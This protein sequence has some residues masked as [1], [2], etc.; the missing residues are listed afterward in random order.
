MKKLLVL[1]SIFILFLVN[2]AIAD[3]VTVQFLGVYGQTVAISGFWHTG[4]V[5]A[6]IYKLKVDGSATDSFCIDLQDPAT[7]IP[8]IY[9]VVALG[10]APDTPLGPMGAAKALAIERL[11]K[12]YYSPIMTQPQAAALQVA[13]WDC[14]VD[15]DRNINTGNFQ[16]TYIAAQALL[17]NL[18]NLTDYTVLLGLTNPVY[19]DFLKSPVPEP[20]TMLLLGC[21]LIGLAAYGRKKFFEK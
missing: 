21:G 8:N 4:N 14:V 15:L 16:S 17:D 3:T 10:A 11:W 20:A 18:P 2:V 9:E 13:I 7:P 19:Q 12:A 6:G 1:S 5:S